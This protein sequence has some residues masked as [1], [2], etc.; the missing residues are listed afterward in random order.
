MSL[1][2]FI[3]SSPTYLP[4]ASFQASLPPSPARL[5]LLVS[6]PWPTSQ[7]STCSLWPI[8][9]LWLCPISIQ[10]A[11]NSFST[12]DFSPELSRVW[13]LLKHPYLS[14]HQGPCAQLAHCG[15]HN[16]SS[17]YSLPQA[18]IVLHG[19]TGLHQWSQKF[20]GYLQQRHHHTQ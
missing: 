13:G 10:F 9:S 16:K 11:Q 6:F 14:A 5:L 18:L 19:T 4:S 17:T 8:L 3:A 1:G 7:H 20:E 12:S 2:T 15:S